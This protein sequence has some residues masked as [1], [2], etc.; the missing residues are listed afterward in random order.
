MSAGELAPG[1]EGGTILRMTAAGGG[2]GK[3]LAATL[4]PS[5]TACNASAGVPLEACDCGNQADCG[6]HRHC[7]RS[8]E[9]IVQV[10]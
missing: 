8:M 1:S 4:E 7:P 3:C 2:A 5:P 10:L 6:Y 9:F